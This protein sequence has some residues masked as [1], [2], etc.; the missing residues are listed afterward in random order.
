MQAKIR[1][2]I[3]IE[4]KVRAQIITESLLHSS[5]LTQ[6]VVKHMHA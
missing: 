6:L 5:P 4:K 3:E 2:Y 1:T